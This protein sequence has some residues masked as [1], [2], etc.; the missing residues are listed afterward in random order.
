VTINSPETNITGSITVLPETFFDAAALMRQH[1]EARS[2]GGRSSLVVTGGG[3]MLV[4]PDRSYLPAFY[5]DLS[6]E[7]SVVPSATSKVKGRS[8]YDFPM[9][10]VPSLTLGCNSI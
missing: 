3:T 7:D 9:A 1:C 4:E 5:L 6:G 8:A 10:K 2:A